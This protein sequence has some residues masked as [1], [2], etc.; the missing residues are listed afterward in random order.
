MCTKSKESV[1]KIQGW[2]ACSISK[3]T[4]GD[5]QTGWMREM[6]VPVTWMCGHWLSVRSL[7]G[8]SGEYRG[9]SM[10]DVS[11]LVELA[12]SSPSAESP[13]L[14]TYGGFDWLLSGVNV[15]S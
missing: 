2:V 6:S 8:V 3:K 11:E 14:V 4:L 13:S 7:P 5:T 12:R 15:S 10:L 9:S 1:A